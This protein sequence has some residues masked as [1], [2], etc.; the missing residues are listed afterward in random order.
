MKNWVVLSTP[1]FCLTIPS[2]V[3]HSTR[4]FTYKHT[5][6]KQV[7]LEKASTGKRPLGLS[8]FWIIDKMAERWGVSKNQKYLRSSSSFGMFWVYDIQELSQKIGPFRPNMS[9]RSHFLVLGLL[10]GW[11]ASKTGL[12]TWFSE[13]GLILARKWKRMTQMSTQPFW[14]VFREVFGLRF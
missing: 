9:D 5:S 13:I 1:I 12:K 7:S 3:S 2:E 6:K 4:S 10:R 8:A 11:N 14:G